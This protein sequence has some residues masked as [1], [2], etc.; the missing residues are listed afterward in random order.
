MDINDLKSVS[1]G[2]VRF[3]YTAA[4]W[5]A[6]GM[7]AVSILTTVGILIFNPP[8]STV[9]ILAFF[10]LSVVIGAIIFAISIHLDYRESILIH[11]VIMKYGDM[12]TELG[13]DPHNVS[14]VTNSTD[15]RN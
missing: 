2:K 7:I 14:K 4:I 11:K 6:I 13:N 9:P 1:L 3:T 15:R 8:L 5:L 12:K 10:A